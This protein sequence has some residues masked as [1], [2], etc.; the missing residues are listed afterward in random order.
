[1]I[2]VSI[3]S[4]PLLLMIHLRIVH[5]SLFIHKDILLSDFNLKLRHP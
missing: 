3:V 1:M 4:F 5:V 2:I